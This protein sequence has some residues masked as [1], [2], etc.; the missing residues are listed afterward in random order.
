MA[1]VGTI[2]RSQP[3]WIVESGCGPGLPD[4]LSGLGLCVSGGEASVQLRVV[5]HRT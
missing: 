3:P 1:A 4:G 2:G 5:R